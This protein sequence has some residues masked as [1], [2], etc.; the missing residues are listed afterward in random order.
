M[1]EDRVRESA[2]KILGFKDTETAISGVG[3]ITSFN[4]LGF[5]GVKDRPDGWYLPNESTFPAIIL[6]A[7]S[8]K[9][10]FKKTHIDELLKNTAIVSTKY[11]K[12][13]GL[14][15]NGNV[16]QI[17]KDGVFLRE[18]T[19]LK[20]KEY[21]LSLF[22]QNKI[23]TSKIYTITARINNNLHFNFGIK[24][25]YHRMIF[26][27]CAL[28]AKRYGSVLIKGMDYTTF[29]T[30]IHATLAKSFDE[31]RKQ[32]LK[33][34]ILLEAYS[35][36][37][38]NITEKQTAID[39]FI[40]CVEDI[41]D[42]INSDFWNGEDVMAIF[43]NEFNR[44]KGKSESGQVFTPDHI[45]SLIYE[46]IGINKDDI[47]LDAACGSGAFLVKAMCNMI[48]EAGGNSTDKAK[49]IKQ[50]QLFGIE[51][52][53][54]I[55]ALACA[56]MLIHKDGKTNLEQ[57]DSRTDEAKKWIKSKRITKVL[58]NPPFENK[59][60][61]IEIVANVL[62]SVD[63][64]TICAFI[65]PDNKLETNLNKTKK[66]LQKHTLSKIIK[67]PHE[68]FSGTTTSIFI[69]KSGIPQ[70]NNKIFACAILDDGLETIKNQGRQDIKNKWE[71]I[72]KYWVD[73]IY[74]QSG[75]NSIQWLDPKDNLSYKVQEKSFNI[76]EQNFK[77]IVLDYIFFKSNINPNAFKNK[78]LDF[79]L[80]DNSQDINEQ[81]VNAIRD[82]MQ[83]KNNSTSIDISK[84]KKFI[85]CGKDG[86]FK[87][88]QP[89]ARKL[90]EY[91]N[92][93]DVPFVASGA[94]NNGIEK[95]VET[96]EILDKGNSITVS[97][98]GG[99][100][101]YQE[102]DFIGRGG[103]GSAIKILYSDNL[104]EKNA[105][106]ICAVLQKTLSKYDYTTMLSGDKLKKEFIYLPAK[107]DGQPDF[108]FM[109]NY[110]EKLQKQ[111]EIW[112]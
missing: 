43:F 103:A 76:N 35:S 31:A 59:Y 108:L 4:Q 100:S 39:D 110:I 1:T 11:K 107:K 112:V 86:I 101:F 62:E 25:L 106:F 72:E 68:I 109:E 105:L 56:N 29:H 79:V 26:T 67:L 74:K 41:S 32:N 2:G 8:E 50:S 98:I 51:F 93:G 102:K 9:T 77:K 40:E 23:D 52:D 36:I 3:Q 73:V 48:K 14:L 30:S 60:G 83:S 47:I 46:I 92:D 5:I 78:I 34:N 54:E 61:C 38:M 12:N 81:L 44:Y 19:E 70:N 64:D 49:A 88:I 27:A 84:W 89:K 75:D 37:K 104:N 21:Y 24:N 17:Y 20:N 53:K 96:D 6:E 91:L 28:V 97:A 33:L 16:V 111:L 80:F 69:F 66:I 99:F 15:Y 13:I 82:K 42:N 71:K 65:M 18:E 90:T 94:F 87:L 10:T 22:T 63:R 95:Y 7:K 85:I 58:M 45:T 55:Y 57:L